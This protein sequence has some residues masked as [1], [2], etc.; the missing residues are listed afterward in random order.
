MLNRK[1]V[2]VV[3]AL[4][5]FFLASCKESEPQRMRLALEA[6]DVE[7]KFR[8]ELRH[9]AVFDDQGIVEQIRPL[10]A[11]GKPAGSVFEPRPDWLRF[12][13]RIG[14]DARTVLV[15]K[16]PV[17]NDVSWNAIARAGAALDV[18]NTVELAENE[19]E[20]GKI[21]RDK[22]GREYRARL[23]TCGRSTMA[24]LSEWNLLIGAVHK[25][26]MD[27]RFSRHGWI[28]N[29]YSDAELKVGYDGSLSWCQEKTGELRVVRGYFTVS[30][31]HASRPETSTERLFWRPIL[32]L[33]D[34]SPRLSSPRPIVPGQRSPDGRSVFVRQIDNTEL[35]GAHSG[36]L[37]QVPVDGGLLLGSG[38]PDW[39]HFRRDG[40]TLLVAARPV[41][42]TVT[43]NSIARA[44]A[45]R[46]D[47]GWV[48]AGWWFF[49][50]DATVRDVAGHEYRVRLL[51][52]GDHTLDHG[53]EWNA[54]I[55]GVHV[56]DEDFRAKAN[57]LYGWID[58]PL[59]DDDLVI[60]SRPGAASWCMERKRV[61]S[62][63][64]AVNRGFLTVSRHHATMPDYV[65]WGFGW[66]PV[67]ELVAV[68]E[69]K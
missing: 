12:D 28:E 27:F 49:R 30:R 46:G 34:A 43:W 47:G 8:G 17:M 44:G 60:G 41:L 9:E 38:R 1:H 23:P 65:G 21:V 36:I 40:K 19:F 7:V 29:P 69:Q 25:G 53:A 42:T 45:V 11:D 68:A 26:D 2:T 56:G 62:K 33:V 57:G 3:S 39:L 67:L 37:D 55:G 63:L 22:H 6:S 66:R 32:E 18:G 50:Q 5:L 54:L 14:D 64:L 59:D 16:Y 15:A 58:D 48:R 51:A 35:F 4:C 31:F 61:R 24:D 52:C 10:D 20:Q 13:Y